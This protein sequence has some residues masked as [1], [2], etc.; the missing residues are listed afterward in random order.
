[1]VLCERIVSGSFTNRCCRSTLKLMSTVLS[2]IK[3]R[4]WMRR[5]F[6]LVKEPIDLFEWF[7]SI[8]EPLVLG[9]SLRSSFEKTVLVILV[10][11]SWVRWN[12][13]ELFIFFEVGDIVAGDNAINSCSC[14]E[15]LFVVMTRVW[16]C[17]LV[18]C[19]EWRFWIKPTVVEAVFK[20]GLG[21]LL[22]P[23][24]LAYC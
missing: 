22:L 8:I 2:P 16:R 12:L 10:V 17:L 4:S 21:L 23:S 5:F 20:P 19:R 6:W 11:S 14:I 7:R 3:K 18:E 24:R 1:M 9:T 15:S 13:S